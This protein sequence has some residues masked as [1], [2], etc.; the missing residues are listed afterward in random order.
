[1]SARAAQIL[2]ECLVRHWADSR[3]DEAHAVVTRSGFLLIARAP[4]SVTLEA[5]LSASSTGGAL[6]TDTR[7]RAESD[8]ASHNSAETNTSALVGSPGIRLRVARR[9]AA[10]RYGSNTKAGAKSPAA[11]AAVANAAALLDDAL[12]ARRTQS[13]HVST[14]AL[15]RARVFTGGDIPADAP[16]VD[17]GKLIAV[18]AESGEGYFFTVDEEELAPWLAA[19][20][21]ASEH[22]AVPSPSSAYPRAAVESP[23][24]STIPSNAHLRT[25]AATLTALRRLRHKPELIFRDPAATWTV[26]L[27]AAG[28]TGTQSIAAASALGAK[29]AAALQRSAWLAIVPR[30]LPILGDSFTAGAVFDELVFGSAYQRIRHLRS[31][32]S[33]AS[34]PRSSSAAESGLESSESSDA[35]EPEDVTTLEWRESVERVLCFESFQKYLVALST[36]ALRPSYAWDVLREALQLEPG[37][38][39]V[40]VEE[41]ISCIISVDAMAAGFPVSR[42]T[43]LPLAVP[44][45]LVSQVA[46]AEE[47]PAATFFSHAA[48]TYHEFV[49]ERNAD[50]EQEELNRVVDSESTTEESSGDAGDEIVPLADAGPARHARPPT[51][52]RPRGVTQSFST[53][54][55]LRAASGAPSDAHSARPRGAS[56]ALA[57]EIDLLLG[58]GVAGGSSESHRE[59]SDSASG[60]GASESA[61]GGAAAGSGIVH[62]LRTWMR[63]AGTALSST[64]SAAALEVVTQTSGPGLLARFNPLTR[65]ASSPLSSGGADRASVVSSATGSAGG[66]G[67]DRD[68][69][70]E[71]FESGRASTRASGT[72]IITSRH[73]FISCG[74]ECIVIPVSSLSNV[75]DGGLLCVRTEGSILGRKQELDNGLLLS[76]CRMRRVVLDTEIEGGAAST[77]LKTLFSIAAAV[78]G[79]TLPPLPGRVATP[80]PCNIQFAVTLVF[81]RVK[82]LLLGRGDEMR[83]GGRRRVCRDALD[84]LICAARLSAAHAP[85]LRRALVAAERGLPVAPADA[86]S[87]ALLEAAASALPLSRHFSLGAPDALGH[88]PLSPAAW[89]R[90]LTRTQRGSGVFEFRLSLFSAINL[91]R[92]RA[93]QRVTGRTTRALL[94]CTSAEGGAHRETAAQVKSFML[95]DD[96]RPFLHVAAFLSHQRETQV[97]RHEARGVFDRKR[98]VAELTEMLDR[99]VHPGLLV[100]HGVL[101]VCSWR[102]PWVTAAALVLALSFTWSPALMRFPSVVL[103]CTAFGV[104][105]FEVAGDGARAS[106][107]SVLSRPRTARSR[108]IIEAVRELRTTLGAQQRRLARYNAY[109][110]RVTALL[111]ARDAARTTLL[112]VGLVTAAL[113]LSFL[114]ARVT[115]SL[116]LAWLFSPRRRRIEGEPSLAK[117]CWERFFFGVAIQS[118]RVLDGADE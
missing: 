94:L 48:A 46:A 61:S 99:F 40:R 77:P 93:L 78:D 107:R 44:G 109:L 6:P 72:L 83:G 22:V 92:T 90:A 23:T 105:A 24:S 108:S 111:T 34:K 49:A 51:Q 110:A 35:D 113:A 95:R 19:L 31:T 82:D 59:R 63:S 27:R 80:A 102:L 26:L 20:S 115:I 79:A 75:R 17:V 37:E 4:H 103:L 54:T 47:L 36:K 5:I 87:P 74:A 58:E 3:F 81:S 1:M 114:P 56:D 52:G 38:I 18:I 97:R 88:S 66:A 101:F 86:P 12:P 33:L 71:F 68:L 117:L 41:M 98:L 7:P 8:A 76:N 39:V 96:P 84:E 73:V 2:H 69:F 62:G 10:T 55:R 57:E 100:Y 9:G 29:G 112:V 25:D 106:L 16:R 28:P 43:P 65:V 89:R 21:S 32:S 42:V 15:S 67:L 116:W 14:I 118:G 50:D 13:P 53:P 30:F 64:A 60:T 45:A 70:S 104:G 85:V 11:L 91:M